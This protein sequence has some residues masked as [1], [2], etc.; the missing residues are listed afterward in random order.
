VLAPGWSVFPKAVADDVKVPAS[1]GQESFAGIVIYASDIERSVKFYTDVMGLKIVG[2]VQDK[3]ELTEILLSKSGKLFDDTILTLQPTKGLPE[4]SN[5]DRLKF[6]TLI[7]TATA[8]DTVA[9][10]LQTAGYEVTVRD[11]LHLMTKDPDGYQIMFYQFG[12]NLKAAQK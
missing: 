4:R 7:F 5:P 11:P 6:G 2:R 3:G 10:R 1:A 8:N 9:E 12:K